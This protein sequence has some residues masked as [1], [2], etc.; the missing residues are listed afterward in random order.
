MNSYIA[1]MWE[2]RYPL[3]LLGSLFCLDSVHHTALWYCPWS[4]CFE[5]QTRKKTK[6]TLIDMTTH[7]QRSIGCPQKHSQDT[8]ECGCHCKHCPCG[9]C[10]HVFTLLNLIIVSFVSFKNLFFDSYWTT[11]WFV[12]PTHSSCEAR[13][14]L[15]V[16]AQFLTQTH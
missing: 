6:Q 1:F 8:P 12:D 7:Q 11:C 16:S 13:T 10:C 5:N 9:G 15:T 14:H 3:R 4:T 2:A